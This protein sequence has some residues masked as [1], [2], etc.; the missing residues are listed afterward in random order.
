MPGWRLKRSP[1]FRRWRLCEENSRVSEIYYSTHNC[2][3]NPGRIVLFKVTAEAANLV[4][5]AGDRHAFGR[6]RSGNKANI[7]QYLGVVLNDEVKSIAFIRSRISDQGEISGRF[8]KQ[9]AEDLALILRSGALPAPLK[10]IEVAD[11]K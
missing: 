10:I 4:G 9:S 3:A 6:S 2:S 5:D 7:N 8:T 1:F 11:N